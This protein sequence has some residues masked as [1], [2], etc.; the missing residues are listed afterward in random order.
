MNEND[1]GIVLSRPGYGIKSSIGR[2]IKPA[3]GN[4]RPVSDTE[5]CSGDALQG[6]DALTINYS[7]KCEV[8]IKVY[9][10]RLAD[11][12]GN[13]RK[14]HIDCLTKSGLVADDSEAEIQ[15]TEEPQQKVENGGEEQVEIRLFYPAVDYN[16]LW[17][18]KATR[19]AKRQD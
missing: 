4:K 7:G 15:L 18:K 11:P 16:N 2:A 10:R 19:A 13:C 14:Y 5:Y 1:L 6:K 17:I 9:R 8:R 3:V 12:D